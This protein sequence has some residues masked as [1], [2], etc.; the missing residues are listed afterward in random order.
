MFVSSPE[1]RKCT[2]GCRFTESTPLQGH[3]PIAFPDGFSPMIN[4]DLNGSFFCDYIASEDDNDEIIRH[5]MSSDYGVG[6]V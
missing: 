6:A 2:D 5:G 4:D 3:I 1:T